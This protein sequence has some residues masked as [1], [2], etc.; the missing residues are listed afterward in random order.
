VVG[1]CCRLSTPRSQRLSAALVRTQ[2]PAAGSGLVDR[3]PDEG[4][5]KAEAPG[6]VSGLDDA[7]SQ[8]VIDCLHENLFTVEDEPGL[9]TDTYV[10]ANGD[11]DRASYVVEVAD[12]QHKMDQVL[13]FV[14]GPYTK[15]AC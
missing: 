9:L 10:F 8:K 14:G 1:A 11:A 7:E 13:G 2:P 12:G 15:R 6:H 3:A 5:A 4:V